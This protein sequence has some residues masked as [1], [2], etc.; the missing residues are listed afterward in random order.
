[1]TLPKKKCVGCDVLFTPEIEKQKYCTK[2][3][4]K[5]CYNQRKK[6]DL[7]TFV[8]QKC[9]HRE[10]LTFNPKKNK[11]RWTNY[12]CPSCKNRR[13]DVAKDSIFID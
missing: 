5:R 10:R 13:A 11:T 9:G 2:K 3:C 7:P 4:F 8:C 12:L 1:M 6:E